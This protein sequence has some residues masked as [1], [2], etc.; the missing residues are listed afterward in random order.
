MPGLLAPPFCHQHRHRFPAL[1]CSFLPQVTASQ[2]QLFCQRERGDLSCIP[3]GQ[4]SSSF[5]DLLPSPLSAHHH[6]FLQETKGTSGSMLAVSWVQCRLQCSLA[7]SSVMWPFPL[8]IGASQAAWWWGTINS[9]IL[10]K[11]FSPSIPL[12]QSLPSFYSQCLWGLLSQ[13]QVLLSHLQICSL[14]NL[15]SSS[16]LVGPCQG[17]LHPHT[18]LQHSSCLWALVVEPSSSRAAGAAQWQW[19]WVST[20]QGRESCLVNGSHTTVAQNPG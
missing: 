14:F 16:V 6:D 8:V 9:T 10:S 13:S 7:L 17:R 2:K 15:L 3:G 11:D 5:L 12:L 4:G 18:G 20:W 1:G 19:Q